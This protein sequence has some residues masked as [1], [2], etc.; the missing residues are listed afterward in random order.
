MKHI[1]AIIAAIMVS[2]SLFIPPAI[3]SDTCD[4]AQTIAKK[5]QAK[6]QTD[7][8]EGLKLFI[9]AQQLCGDN[10]RYTYNLGLAYYQYGRLDDAVRQVEA[11]VVKDGKNTLWLNNLAAMLLQQG[12]NPEKTLTYADQAARQDSKNGAVQETLARARFA[13]GQHFSALQGLHDVAKNSEKELTATYDSLLDTYLATQLEIISGGQVEEGLAT[14]AKLDFEPQAART[15]ALVLARSGRG[16]EALEV[17]AAANK[18]FTNNSEIA[19]VQDEVA[20]QVA[21][22]LYETFQAGNGAK[23]VQKAKSMAETYQVK[24][25]VEAYEKLLAALLEDATSIAVPEAVARKNVASKSSGRTEQLLAG[26]GGSAASA[27]DINLSVDIDDQIP[28]GKAAGKY[29]VAVVIGNRTYRQ[30]GVPAVDYAERDARIMNSY[31]VK[32]M[33]FGKKNII[34]VENAGLAD[35]NKIF[36]SAGDHMGQLFNFVKPGESRVFIYYVGHGAPELASGDAYF[37]PVDADPQ[38]L[39]TNGYRLETF[40]NNLGKLPATQVT[41]VLDACFSGNSDKGLLFSGVSS[42]TLKVKENFV[43]PPNTVVFASAQNDQ[44]STWYPEKR[45]SLFTYYFLKGLGGEADSDRNAQLT[46]AE[47]EDYLGENVPFMARRLKGN[48]QQPSISGDRQQVM[49]VLQ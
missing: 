23:A 26:L 40:Y 16:E 44:V 7:Q 32:T 31:L 14:L 8:A 27:A 3:A 45:H 34:Y 42:L 1:S 18:K 6:F 43:K 37:V 20:N 47:L 38:Y 2:A 41:V 5:A 10:P 25:L 30:A 11:A 13:A 35:F 9:K 17:A 49:A 21:L 4:L 36:G 29:D 22:S 48:E 12:G 46:V 33:G 24:P 28:A 19:Q 39:K 15:R